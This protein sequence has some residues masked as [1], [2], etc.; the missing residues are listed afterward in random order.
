M[1]EEGGETCKKFAGNGD[2]FN[3]CVLGSKLEPMS[4]WKIKILKALKLFYP[5]FFI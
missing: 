5:L 2:L 1:K 3:A 4:N